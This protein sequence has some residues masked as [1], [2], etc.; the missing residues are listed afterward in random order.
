MTQITY[1]VAKKKLEADRI[2]TIIQLVTGWTI[3]EVAEVL[4]LDDETIK[5]FWNEYS[6]ETK[7]G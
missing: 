7:H 5:P 2:K 6:Q 4:L 1:R 3:R